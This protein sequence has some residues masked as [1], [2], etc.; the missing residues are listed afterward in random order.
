[1]LRW[2]AYQYPGYRGYQYVLERDQHSGEFVPTANLAH[3]PILG[4]CSPFGESSIKA[5]HPRYFL[6]R[7]L[8]KAF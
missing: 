8:N 1:M 2:V 4:C 5:P 7:S 6:L 3:R